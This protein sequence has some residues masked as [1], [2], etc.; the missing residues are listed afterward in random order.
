MVLN[1]VDLRGKPV[2][3]LGRSALA[4]VLPRAELD[5]AAAIEAVAP[6]CDDVRSR[7]A[8]AVREHTVRF[9]GVD[10]A[11]TRVPREALTAA[12]AGLTAGDRRGQVVEVDGATI[13]RSVPTAA[14]ALSRRATAA[15][16]ASCKA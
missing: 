14:M 6:V 4:G 2:A 3:E 11:T 13:T 9:D 12:L 7:G 16:R 15:S 1:R 5:V 8:A 10:L